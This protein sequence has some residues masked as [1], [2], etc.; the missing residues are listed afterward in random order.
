MTQVGP[1]DLAEGRRCWLGLVE[2]CHT[3]APGGCVFRRRVPGRRATT[4]AP[5]DRSRSGER[6]SPTPWR[7]GTLRGHALTSQETLHPGSPVVRGVAVRWG[8]LL[9]G[10]CS[11]DRMVRTA[12]S[13]RMPQM[14]SYPAVRSELGNAAL[15]VGSP[16]TAS[17][18]FLYRASSVTSRRSPSHVGG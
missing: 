12:R 13:A 5:S 4:G 9:R 16:S 3:P 2:G 14:K 10:V 17:F 7:G 1:T 8:C 15:S 6:A 18:L 11:S